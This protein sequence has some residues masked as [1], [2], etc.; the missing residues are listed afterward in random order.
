VAE[1]Y[2]VADLHLAEV[3]RT[4][5]AAV[6][7]GR[8]ESQPSDPV[9]G[10]D[11]LHLRVD[12]DLLRA[13]VVL[14]GRKLMPDFPQCALRLARFKGTTKTEFLDQRQ[15]H[16][17]AFVLLD[18]AVHF[19]MRHIPMAG[20]IKPG[21][22]ERQDTPL[23]PRWRCGK[24]SSMQSGVS[25]YPQPQAGRNP[26]GI[27]KPSLPYAHCRV[28][29]APSRPCQTVDYGLVAHRRMRKSLWGIV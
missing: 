3:E 4:L 5:R 10:L 17:H 23:Y 6:H 13:V 9:E 11:R 20:R 21:A 27:R 25:S 15:L 28:P 18:E 29:G 24:P 22:L 1:G 12:G 19:I 16:G 7:Q 26:A 14:F 8:L 2:T